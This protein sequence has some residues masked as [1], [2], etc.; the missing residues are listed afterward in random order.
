MINLAQLGIH[1]D[2]E[3]AEEIW[4]EIQAKSPGFMGKAQ[5]LP[6]HRSYF[7]LILVSSTPMIDRCVS[8]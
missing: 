6:Y 2:F 3:A 1:D 4:G 5:R 7:C 8:A